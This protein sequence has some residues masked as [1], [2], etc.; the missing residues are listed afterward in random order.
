MAARPLHAA[1]LPTGPALLGLLRAALD[2][3]PALLPVDPH[4]PGP[5]RLRLLATLRPKA[6]ATPGGLQRF[7][8]GV[9]VDDEV[10]LVIATSGSTGEPKGVQLSAAALRHSATAVLDR[11]QAAPADRWLCCLPTSHIGGVGVLMRSLVAGTDPVLLD[12]FSVNTFAQAS[13]EHT[14]VVPTMLQRL[15]DA[16]ADLARFRSVLVG[17]AALPAELRTRATEAG[18]TIVPTYGTTETAGGCVYDG[19]PLD[20]VTADVRHDGRIR[21]TGPVLASGYR[22]RPDLTSEAFV[23]GWLVTPDLG[24]F[25]DGGRLQVLGRDDDVIVTGGVNVAATAVSDL[26]S[27]HPGVAQV[28]VVGRPDAQWG[29]LVVAIVVP[30]D[31]AAPPTLT[32]LRVHVAAEAAAPLAPRD[33]VLLD[34]MPVLPSGK[35]DRR[36]LRELTG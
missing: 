28:A 1:V 29:Q 26:I 14:A 8:D 3:G 27:T 15:L 30:A 2:G 33:L 36:A 32:Q 24:R 10:A 7:D 6:V 25:A 18:A 35:I 17:G 12:R 11:I 21:I 20:G 19:V 31:P 22:L 16:G 4:L 34:A 23:D 13:A 5:A 9:P